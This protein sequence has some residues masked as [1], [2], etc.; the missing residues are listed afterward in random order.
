MRC[1]HSL[2]H[3]SDTNIDML[4]LAHLESACLL[5]WGATEIW[6]WV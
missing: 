6:V 1:K 3:S 2:E 5:I 4:L